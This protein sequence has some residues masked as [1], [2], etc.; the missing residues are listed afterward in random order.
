LGDA[1]HPEGSLNGRRLAAAIAAALAAVP[2]AAARADLGGMEP[3]PTPTLVIVIAVDQMR[4]DYLDRFGSML[5]GGLARLRRQGA[6]FTHAYQDHGV[7]ETAPG[8]ASILSGRVP[9]STGIIRNSDG[10]NDS[11]APLVETTGPGASPERFMG[12]TLVDWIQARYPAA[13]VLSVSRKDRSAILMVGVSK[14]PVY[15]FSGGRFTTSRYYADTLPAWV[16]GINSEVAAWHAP[17]DQ[18]N[19]LLSEARYPEDDSVPWEHGGRDLVFPHRVAPLAVTAPGNG[20]NVVDTPYMDS[21]TLAF[22][23]RG[24]AATGLGRGPA[25]DILA[26]G[27]SSSDAVGHAWGPDSREIRDQV[28][29]LDRWLGVFLDS[30]A[31]LCDPARTLIVLTSDH[32]ITSYPETL[33]AA[34]HPEA[35]YVVTDTVISAWQYALE[36]RLGPGRWIGREYGM[37][38][39][40]LVA[41]RAHRVN[42]DSLTDRLAADLRRVPGVLRVDTRRTLA[43]GDTA[44]DPVLRR[45]R[46]AIPEHF[47]IGAMITLKPNMVFGPPNGTARHGQNSDSDAHVPLVFWYPGIRAARYAERVSTVDIAPTLAS[48]LGVTP[49]EPLSGRV[50]EQ[51]VNRR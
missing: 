3:P 37:V 32:G 51:V 23:L 5:T 12:T 38:L 43:G 34:G 28:V 22:A 42:A 36:D 44:R 2:V 15:W 11:T 16:R 27:L 6:Q 31:K 21:L 33:R 18:W 39:L 46:H 1:R 49:S 10:V 48:I 4:G 25:P 19:L 7:T 30:L 41:L 50:L 14:S 13:R 35:G 17:G 20:L 24:V 29:R 47:P 45:W 40:D 9:A 8:H 26:L